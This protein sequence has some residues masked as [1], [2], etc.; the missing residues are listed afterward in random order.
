MNVFQL[1]TIKES[2]AKL[3]A[4]K[5]IHFKNGWGDKPIY[6]FH[7]LDNSSNISTKVFHGIL[8]VGA[9]GVRHRGKKMCK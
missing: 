6:T 2:W 7:C 8:L 4:G 3:W 1:N 9:D 5:D